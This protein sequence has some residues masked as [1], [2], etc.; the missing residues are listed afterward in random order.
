MAGRGI[1]RIWRRFRPLP[2]LSINLSKTGL[3]ASVGPRG[4]QYTVG[5]RG[6][7]TTVGLPG[8]GFYWT[9]HGK[10]SEIQEAA[11]LPKPY[12][13]ASIFTPGYIK[14]TIRGLEAI[15]ADDGA[16]A[17]RHLGKAPNSPDANYLAGFL[18]LAHDSGEAAIQNFLAARGQLMTLGNTFDQYGLDA[19][20]VYSLGLDVNVRIHPDASGLAIGLAESYLLTD[21]IGAACATLQDAIDLDPRDHIARAFLVRILWHRPDQNPEHLNTILEAAAGIEND[22]ALESYLLL[23]RAR[24]LRA[25]D[26]GYQGHRSRSRSGPD[27]HDYDI[28][29][30]KRFEDF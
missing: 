22:T 8:T 28:Y 19:S 10:A 25:L 26:L 11:P 29:V 23:Y 12:S 7:R 30:W 3:S 15:A 5:P 13:I 24:A 27:R 20:L 9:S 17:L 14:N 21:Q 4:A 1:F 18:C 16:K 2:G 6:S